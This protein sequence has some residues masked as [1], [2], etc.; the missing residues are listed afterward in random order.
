VRALAW[1]ACVLAA[2]VAVAAVGRIGR[3]AMTYAA[4]ASPWRRSF[5][6]F[7]ADRGAMFALFVLILLALLAVS[8][9]MLTAYAP[10]AQLNIVQLKNL[11]PSSTFPFGTDYASHDVLT[12]VLYGARITLAVSLLAAGVTVA[13]GAA[14]GAVAGFYGGRIDAVMM[15]LTDAAMSVPRILLLI[16]VIAVAQSV[17]LPALILLIGLTGW[18][19]TSRLVRAQVLALREQDF[20]VAAR[21][22][23]ARDREILWRHLMP[24]VASTVIV[25]GTLALGHVV[26]LEAALSF[27]GIGVRPP[28]PSW[29][30]IIQEGSEN[31]TAFWW[32]S[33]FPGI[34]IVI[35][36]LAVNVFGDGLR[37]A[38]DPR[39]VEDR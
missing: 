7:A 8:A 17:S 26:Y 34:A 15:R 6:R 35:T 21:A 23:G 16:A 4:G 31:I 38:F 25:A 12:R 13:V 2:A 20:A 18:F 9:P 22:L 30:N 14:W 32:M 3:S 27:L 28:T 39:Q 33:L 24:N 19:G 37:D 29:G 1:L 10:D 11:P 5:E 36:C